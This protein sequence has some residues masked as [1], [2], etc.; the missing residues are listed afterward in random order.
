MTHSLYTVE[1]N[2]L[3]GIRL[4]MP[5]V[6]DIAYRIL[7]NYSD[8]LKVRHIAVKSV[9]LGTFMKE[10]DLWHIKVGNAIMNINPEGVMYYFDVPVP[11]D[12]E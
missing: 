10:T 3:K 1:N 9:T 5:Y 4:K 7:G 8:A 2:R 12:V 11:K 6:R